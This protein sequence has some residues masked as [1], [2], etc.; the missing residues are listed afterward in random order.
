MMKNI[1]H[2]N[3]NKNAG[4]SILMSDKV[5]SRIRSII[6]VRVIL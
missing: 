6:T 2:V 4:K 3:Y 5:D 1:K